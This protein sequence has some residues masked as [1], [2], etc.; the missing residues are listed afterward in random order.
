M[1]PQFLGRDASLGALLLF[2]LSHAVLGLLYLSG[3]VAAM[4]RVRGFLSRRRTRRA[5][6]ALTG[7]ALLGLGARLAAEGA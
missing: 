7:A 3:L 6:D 4:H 5:L 1:L 2:A